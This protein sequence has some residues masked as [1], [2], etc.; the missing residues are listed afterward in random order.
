VA[1]FKA[2]SVDQ[3]SERCRAFDL[4]Q[5]VDKNLVTLR[6]G[7]PKGDWQLDNQTALGLPL[8]WRACSSPSSRRGWGARLGLGLGHL[9]PHRQVSFARRH[10]LERHA[11]AGHGRALRF[12]RD[13][14]EV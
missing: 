5:V 8:C 3:T 12:Q 13:I 11:R 4:R 10:P 9:L 1:N 2:V 7:F 6:P 14:A